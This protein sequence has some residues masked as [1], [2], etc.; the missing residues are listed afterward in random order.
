MSE[1]YTSPF[2]DRYGG[3]AM[4]EIWSETSRRKIWRFLWTDLATL[5][6]A[7]GKVTKEELDDL[8]LHSG[9]IDLERSREIEE[10]T[11]HELYAEMQ[12]FAEQCPV[13]G[14]ILHNGAT[15]CDILDNADIIVMKMALDRLVEREV[16]LLRLMKKYIEKYADFPTIAYTHLQKAEFTSLGYRFAFYAQDLLEDLNEH[17]ILSSSLKGKGFKG[18]VGKKE[19]KTIRFP[20]FKI[21]TQVYP[22]KQDFK[23][24]NALANLAASLH[25][26]SFDFRFLQSLGEIS[27][28]F[29]AGQRGSSALPAKRNP[30][31]NEK[32]CG[33][34]RFISSLPPNAWN[35]A[36]NSLMERTLDDSSNRRIVLAQ[37][38]LAAD[39]I[40]E[41][42]IQ[43]WEELEIHEDVIRDNVE[44]YKVQASYGNF[45]EFLV[46]Q[47]GLARKEAY[48]LFYNQ[49]SFPFDLLGE[50]LTM[51]EISAIINKIDIGKAGERSKKLTLS[52]F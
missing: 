29:S 14:R 51:T 42:A 1:N 36:A 12:A 28:G 44:G 40:V 33:I 50:H 13:G 18:A 34:A 31:L 2:S 8:I 25:K 32:I 49:R 37:A 16:V 27:E 11:K 23:V 19:D 9:D 15:S 41:T 48:E 7:E 20:V 52:P 47:R 26:M 35:N 17:W 22:R 6:L 46:N 4:R 39:E 24:L 3:A 10:T 38:F 5:Q 30:I 21:T 43:V 45:I